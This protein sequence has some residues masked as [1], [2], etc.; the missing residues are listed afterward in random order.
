MELT[1]L[2][3]I[4]KVNAQK[5]RDAGIQTPEDLRKLGS[6]EA[7]VLVRMKSDPG[8]CLSMLYGLEGAIRGVR[9]HSLPN[10]VRDELRA[11][12]KTL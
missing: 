12:H 7:L 5:L 4:S 9:W 2:P 8:A 1:D 11:F 3:N 6:K 10:E